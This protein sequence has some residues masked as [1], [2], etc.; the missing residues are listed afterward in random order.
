MDKN[1]PVVVN[2]W[3]AITAKVILV[4]SLLS[5]V[6]ETVVFFTPWYKPI[7]VSLFSTV[8]GTYMLFGFFMLLFAPRK[9]KKSP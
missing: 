2:N 5:I 9:I 7:K 4:L 6:M 8:V 3:Q 1:N